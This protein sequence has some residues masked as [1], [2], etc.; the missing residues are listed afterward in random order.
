[1]PIVHSTCG[2]TS[3]GTHL[4]FT[5]LSRSPGTAYY[6]H[7]R[8]TNPGG[9]TYADGSA[10]A[11]W[12]FTTQVAAPAAFAHT[13]PANGA[14]GQSTSP[15]IGW[16]ASAGATSFEYCIDTT[17]NGACN[18]SCISAGSDTSVGLSGLTAGTV[19]FWQVRAINA[20]GTTYANGAAT[21]FWSFT[22]QV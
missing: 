1:M 3:T 19:Y 21:A 10:T 13:S 15:T 12:S 9:T 8:A 16:S 6:W 5:T 11:F 4:P 18:A 7:V 2:R 14:T 20:G 17:D 22:T